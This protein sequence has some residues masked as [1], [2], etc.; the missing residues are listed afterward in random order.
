MK[1]KKYHTLILLTD[2]QCC[3]L[4]NS[5][6][7][8]FFQEKNKQG[9]RLQTISNFFQNLGSNKKGKNKPDNHPKSSRSQPGSSMS[10][11]YGA[12]LPPITNGQLIN[13]KRSPNYQLPMSPRS[14]ESFS[15][16][17]LRSDKG[18]TISPQN[19]HVYPVRTKNIDQFL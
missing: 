15:P 12:E 17:S 19:K 11:E 10:E 6:V 9:G 18:S 7:D 14:C 1:N 16:R 2:F 13:Q 3:Q 8:F 5:Y 4:R